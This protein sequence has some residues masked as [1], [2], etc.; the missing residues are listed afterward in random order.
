MKNSIL[1]FL[2]EL[3]PDA[4]QQYLMSIGAALGLFVSVAL[5]GIDSMIYALVALTITDL[6]S[7]TIA[8]FKTGK[9]DSCVGFKGIAKKVAIFA[10]VGL[11]N[12]VDVGIGYNHMFRQIIIGAY[13]VNEAGSILENIDL[14]G[15][16]HLIP[17]SIRN[18][19][20][21]LKESADKGE[22]MMP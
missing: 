5:G 13:A 14:L 16:S 9:W 7:G 18:G 11:A 20:A 21:R 15:Y 1:N 22:R 8:A 3:K 10:F 2:G 6:I 4:M 17:S 12:L 19:L